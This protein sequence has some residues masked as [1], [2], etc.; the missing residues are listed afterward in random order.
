MNE[1]NSEEVAKYEIEN[2]KNQINNNFKALLIKVLGFSEAES[3]INCNKFNDLEKIK[4]ISALRLLQYSENINKEIAFMGVLVSIF[5][6]ESLAASGKQ[7]KKDKFVDFMKEN[8]QKNEKIELLSHFLF[9]DEYK[10]RE[11]PVLPLRH[12]MFKEFDC[13]CKFKNKN[14]IDNVDL[15]SS[16]KTSPLCYCLEWLN[17]NIDKLDGY[18]DTLLRYLYEMRS[19]IVHDSLPVLFLP[20]EEGSLMDAYS[21]NGSFR[22]YESYMEPKEYFKIIKNCISQ[23]LKRQN[24]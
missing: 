20:H 6:V 11:G 4:I 3:D 15:C 10:F 13:D 8:L 24:S 5:V 23:Y 2:R 9:S 19:S 14:L 12:V 21:I 18:L 22:S 7:G 17:Q 16:S 1:L